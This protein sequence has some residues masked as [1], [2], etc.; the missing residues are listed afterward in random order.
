MRKK[1]LVIMTTLLL[2]TLLATPLITSVQADKTVIAFS[3]YREVVMGSSTASDANQKTS[4]DEDEHLLIRWG[5]TRDLPY[6]NPAVG[7]GRLY[8]ETV[9]SITN[10]EVPPLTPGAVQGVGNGHGI[11]AVKINITGGTHGVGTLEGFAIMTWEWDF[12]ISPARHV[13]TANYTLMRGTGD[14][15]GAKLDYDSWSI[16]LATGVNKYGSWTVGELVLP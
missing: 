13:Q 12:T 1:I 8:L 6:N 16:R 3:S 11:Y 10:Y 7:A 14:F 2:T 9:R 15:E 5:T 4:Q